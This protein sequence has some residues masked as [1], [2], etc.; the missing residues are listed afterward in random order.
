MIDDAVELLG[1]DQNNLDCAPVSLSEYIWTFLVSGN[2]FSLT[3][4]L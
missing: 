3:P 2:Y 1:E 4:V